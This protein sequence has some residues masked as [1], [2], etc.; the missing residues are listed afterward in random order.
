[1]L[2]CLLYGYMLI[3]VQ[4]VVMYGAPIWYEDFAKNLSVQRPLQKVQRKLAI[5]IIVEYRTVSYEVAMLLA[6]TPLWQE[7]T[8]GH[9]RK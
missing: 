8:K 1:M 9:M 4:S 2:I 5:R 3:M 6:R 7:N